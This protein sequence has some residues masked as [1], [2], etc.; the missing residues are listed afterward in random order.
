MLFQKKKQ[1]NATVKVAPKG[2]AHYLTAKESREI[3]KSNAK[4]IR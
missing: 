2:D 3:A 1:E 4:I